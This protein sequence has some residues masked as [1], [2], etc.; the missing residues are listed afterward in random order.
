M[1]KLELGLT[2]LGLQSTRNLGLLSHLFG[3]KVPDDALKGLD[4][5]LIGLRT[6]EL[7]QQLLEARCRLSPV[8][9]LIEDLHWADSV[10][11][12]L[13]AK[14]IDI[15]AK[16]SLLVITT[17]R[18]EYSPTWLDRSVVTNLPL[19]PLAT[20]DIRHL[21]QER[22]S[23]AA[24]PEG[25][26]QQV[27]DKAEGNPLFTEEILSYLTERGDL[28]TVAGTL[29]F[30]ANAV[31]A[32][33][34]ASVQSILTARVDRLAPKDRALLQT[35]SV[36]GRRFD[37]ELLAT[38]LNEGKVDDR[39]ASM[40]ALDLIH[41]KSKT[42]DFEFKHAL[43]RDARAALHLKIAAEIERR[44][45]NR[46]AEVAEV[47]A[48]HY[49]QTD[50][51][52]KTFVYLAMAGSKCL[53]VYSLDQAS[54][55]FAA[56]LALID[57]NPECASDDQ[58]V[59]FLVPYTLLLNMFQRSKQ[60]IDVVRRHL[61]RIERLGDD[62]RVV[63]I[64]H[65]FIYALLWNA[66]YAEAV[67][68]QRASSLMA[69]RLS[70]SRSR[71]YSLASEIYVSTLADTRM[72]LNDYE[73]L[74]RQ[75]LAA[76]SDTSDGY[77]QCWARFVIGWE[78]IHRGRMNEAR[79]AAHE[80]MEIGQRL[81]DPRTT[82]FGL[83][84]LTWI[85]LTSDSY[86]EALDYS[87]QSLMLAL[88][89]FERD[90][91]TRAKGA[92][93]FLL[94]RLEEGV[95]LL[96]EDRRRCDIDGNFYANRHNTGVF[97]LFEALAGNITTGI[98]LIKQTITVQEKDGCHVAADWYREEIAPRILKPFQSPAKPCCL[99]IA[100]PP[101]SRRFLEPSDLTRRVV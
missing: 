98:K 41:Q 46:L 72:S 14:I 32:A 9:L 1:Q 89:P 49:C 100:Q 80:L 27:I 57:K 38:V 45:G 88:A 20:G 77:I 13:L 10:S 40:H 56:A 83:A 79:N 71:A 74:K 43:V 67:A 97:G 5:V 62:T 76:A 34:P 31:S 85:A 33:L 87:N 50:R 11:T 55:H 78:E 70:D 54:S 18:S 58:I 8:V 42:S 51:A 75:V 63:Q 84:V 95:K 25:L 73:A 59:D 12:E 19:E 60:M 24:L 2:T 92:A 69:N 3:L 39:L 29:E 90:N 7:L 35:A 86:A 68:V 23:V 36:I 6:R 82:G 99:L 17:R 30:N 22:L 66:R 16:L 21:I 53:N 64:H 52:E 4:G 101:P 26:A 47:L 91:A 61:R 81:N 96:E 44:S 15:G 28:R 94:R 48:H 65:H 37:P 93:L